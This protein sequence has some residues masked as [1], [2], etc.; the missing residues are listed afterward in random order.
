MMGYTKTY[1]NDPKYIGVSFVDRK[2]AETKPSENE[3]IS[4]LEQELIDL[5]ERLAEQKKRKIRELEEDIQKI[6]LELE[7][8]S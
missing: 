7:K 3:K 8:D 4:A 6:K 5:K 2:I 1:R